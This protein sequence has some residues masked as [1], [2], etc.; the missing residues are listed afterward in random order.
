[1]EVLA[2]YRAP[3][4]DLYVADMP[5]ASMPADILA[6]WNAMYGVT[7]RPSLLDGRITVP[8]F[9]STLGLSVRIFPPNREEGCMSRSVRLRFC[10]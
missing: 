3:G 10:L 7:L 9:D 5:Y 1:M 2:R 6:E 4:P 8:S